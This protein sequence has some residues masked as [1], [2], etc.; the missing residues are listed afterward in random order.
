MTENGEAFAGPDASGKDELATHVISAS[1]T[2][3]FLSQMSMSSEQIPLAKHVGVDFVYT[4]LK[5]PTLEVRLVRL[6]AWWEE[7][8]MD[9][10]TTRCELFSTSFKEH[11]T[12]RG[13]IIHAGAS[14][15]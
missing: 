3:H 2:Q 9:Y 4:A 15:T 7:G 13:S 12:I 5:H 11:A 10:A 8:R 1:E 6:K 14:R